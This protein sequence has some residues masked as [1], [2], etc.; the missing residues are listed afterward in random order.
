ML[1]LPAAGMAQPLEESPP[2]GPP[3]PQLSFQPDSHD[4]GLQQVNSGSESGLQLQNN[5]EAAALINSL[6]IVGPNVFS[7]NGGATSCF[8]RNLQPGEYCW[9]QVGF[10]PYDATSYT[11]QLRVISEGV[12]FTADLSGEGGRAN[13]GPAVDPT[14]FGAATVGSAG[15]T[16]AIEVTNR[17]NFPGA[18]IA[19]IAGGAV[20]SFHLLD[21]NCTGIPLSPEATCNLLVNFQPLSTG[22]KTARLG[23]FGDSDGGSQIT[24]TGIGAEAES[25]AAPGSP[26]A[27][28]PSSQASGKRRAKP[29]HRRGRHF[30]P[31]VSA[32]WASR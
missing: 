13:I 20:G 31:A 26:S 11:A 10:N 12:S 21:E 17:G 30:R 16:R 25:A 8:G 27:S 1:A 24:L 15:V 28:G 29:R 9:V 32:R 18:F 4:F 2:E 23:L 22:V 6:E 19:V 5:G 14:S 3:L 7:I